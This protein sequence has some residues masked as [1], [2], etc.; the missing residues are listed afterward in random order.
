[1][2]LG[3][4]LQVI[5]VTGSEAIARRGEAIVSLSLLTVD[6]PV[7]AG[8]WVLA[9]SGFVLERLSSAAAADALAL[10]EGPATP[11]PLDPHSPAPTTSEE[12]S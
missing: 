5:E 1:V 6:E 2:C 9:H 11:E 7:T 10:R 3:E 8:D 4:V 12:T